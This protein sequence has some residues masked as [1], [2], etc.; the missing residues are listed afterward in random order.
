[1][2]LHCIIANDDQ[3]IQPFGLFIYLFIYSLILNQLYMFRAMSSPIIRRTW[4]YLQLLVLSTIIAARWCHGWDDI[5]SKT[6]AGSNID[7]QYQK[8]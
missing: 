5:S 7:G 2:T 3:Q 4:L 1:V 6:P 8:R